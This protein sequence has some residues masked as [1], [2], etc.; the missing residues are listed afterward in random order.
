MK[1]D[2]A[3]LWTRDEIIA[4]IKEHLAV[5]PASKFIKPTIADITAYM[6]SKNIINPE[7]NAEKFYNFYES[8]GWKVGKVKMRDWKSS[9]ATWKLPKREA[10]ISG[11]DFVFVSEITK[12]DTLNNELLEFMHDYL[13]LSIDVLKYSNTADELFSDW[14][15]AIDTLQRNGY[16]IK[17][18][19]RIANMA[20]MNEYWR[21]KVYNIPQFA[22]HVEKMSEQ[23]KQVN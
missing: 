20:F 17:T 4:I 18:L 19:R 14:F 5:E 13:R 6:K 23:F 16:K 1:I 3:R 2:E 11:Y 22:K 9:V 21:A 12:A 15:H 7:A 8:K 10:T